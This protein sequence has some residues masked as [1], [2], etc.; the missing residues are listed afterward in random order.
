VQVVV[1]PGG[2]PLHDVG[3]RRTRGEEQHGQRRRLLVLA[4][5]AHDLD[6]ARLRHHPVEHRQVGCRLVREPQRLLAVARDDHVEPRAREAQLD[7]CEDV[8]VV[9]GDEEQRRVRHRP[10]DRQPGPRL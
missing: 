5:R 7:E 6:A 3:V 8:L 10:C 4:Q 9:V 1:G 2:Q